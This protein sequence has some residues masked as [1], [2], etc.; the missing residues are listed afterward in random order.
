MGS[1]VSIVQ[2]DSEKK[3][4]ETLTIQALESLWLRIQVIRG[5]VF[6]K[7]DSF[8]SR[9]PKLDSVLMIYES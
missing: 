1:L 5:D 9:T 6:S 2:V 4:F 8:T 3:R 7:L